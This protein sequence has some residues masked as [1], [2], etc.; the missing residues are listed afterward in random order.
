MG[1]EQ[2]SPSP[3]VL[4]GHHR[5]IRHNCRGGGGNQRDTCSELLGQGFN[6]HSGFLLLAPGPAGRLDELLIAV[7][8][9]A[10]VLGECYNMM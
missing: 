7:I 9:L 8:V 10:V 6:L 3:V 1:V 5:P 4:E 2:P